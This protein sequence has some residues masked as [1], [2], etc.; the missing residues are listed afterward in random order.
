M[1]HNYCKTI[2]I[3]ENF[4]SDHGVSWLASV[5]VTWERGACLYDEAS[6]T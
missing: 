3:D 5:I 1:A 6:R 4:I 2:I